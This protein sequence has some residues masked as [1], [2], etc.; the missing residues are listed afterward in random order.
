MRNEEVK[1]FRCN[2][3]HSNMEIET[4]YSRIKDGRIDLNPPYQRAY[5]FDQTKASKL[6]E[7]ILL[8]IPIPTIY[9]ADKEDFSQEVIDG[10]QR[11]T[12]IFNFMENK[13]VLK[14]LSTWSEL[15]GKTYE[16]LDPAMQNELKRFPLSVVNFYNN[17]DPCVKFE[18]FLRYNIGSEK[19]K[20]Q[21]L[22][23]CLYR[24]YFNDQ[25][26]TLKDNELILEFFNEGNKDK[27]R[28]EIEELILRGLARLNF[29]KMK[30]KTNL[31]VSKSNQLHRFLN[32]FM[33]TFKDDK[34]EV[35]SMIEEY[36]ELL[37]TIKNVLGVELFQKSDKQ[38]Y[39]FRYDVVLMAF[40]DQDKEELLIN[41]NAIK[42]S[43]YQ[44]IGSLESEKGNSSTQSNVESKVEIIQDA[45]QEGIL[46]YI[47]YI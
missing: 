46:N 32:C 21:E 7:S 41:K 39:K 38:T 35:D 27:D 11:L 47:N 17:C 10:L 37:Q 34:E 19:L 3:N 15:N 44:S 36:L 14:G 45:I 22:R 6:I 1:Q 43:V 25:L 20:E 18:I 8:N 16:D 29:E 42:A 4:I 26:K 23:N 31:S 40:K 30:V 28:F 5:V 33:Y 2:H 24:G 9:L 13:L 12:T